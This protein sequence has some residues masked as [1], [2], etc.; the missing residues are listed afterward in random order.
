MDF[1]NGLPIGYISKSHGFKGQVKLGFFEEE[2]KSLLTKEGF[3]F[4]EIDNKGVPFFIEEIEAG[5]LVVKLEDID[6]E[7]AARKICGLKMLSFKDGIEK[8]G[9]VLIGFHLYNQEE[10]K[11]GEIID[12]QDLNGNIV[13]SVGI[14]GQE[15]LIPFHEELVLNIEL[16]KRKIVLSIPEGLLDI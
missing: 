10:K 6:D 12:I 9:N 11:I 13:L 2:Y 16:E 4:L 5:G 1:R 3:L 14:E 15:F 7:D 8:E